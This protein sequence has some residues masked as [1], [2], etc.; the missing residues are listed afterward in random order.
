MYKFAKK[1]K[2][3]FRCLCATN[4]LKELGKDFRPFYIR[5]KNKLGTIKGEKVSSL[6]MQERSGERGKKSKDSVDNTVF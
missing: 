2:V 4:G 1:S 5:R 6:E 3:Q